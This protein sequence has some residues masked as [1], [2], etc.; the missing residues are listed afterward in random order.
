MRWVGI[1]GVVLVVSA[2]VAGGVAISK[3]TDE[4][5]VQRLVLEGSETLSGLVLDDNGGDA[6]PNFAGIDVLTGDEIELR[7][8]AGKP[9]VI[10]VWASWCP[11]CQEQ[12]QEL[13]V[14]ART[15]PEAQ[16][17]GI[18]IND[19]LAQGQAFHQKNQWFWPSVFDDDASI[20]TQLGLDG[21]PATLFLNAD[22]VIVARLTGTGDLER[23]ERGLQE[24][25]VSG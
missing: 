17:L 2:L 10:N 19:T 23:F 21:L 12:A 13:Y 3:A 24:A 18:N 15:H 4:G 11:D 1:I 20:A 6:A 22:Q 25:L 9:V 16:I 14:F 5:T 8:F 7:D